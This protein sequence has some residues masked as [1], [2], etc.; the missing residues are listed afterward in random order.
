MKHNV[1]LSGMYVVYQKIIDSI[2]Q[3]VPDIEFSFNYAHVMGM[4]KLREISRLIIISD[5]FNF[6]SPT[7]SYNATRGQEA[8]EYLHRVDPFLPILIWS[9]RRYYG[10]DEDFPPLWTVEG[11][12]WPLKFD[13][14][15][16][17]EVMDYDLDKIGRISGEFIKGTLQAKQLNHECLD[18]S[19]NYF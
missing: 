16:Y 8:A 10:D 18:M 3:Q 12:P 15:L 6:S 9:G 4:V 19:R 13:S 7:A 11:E 2:K 14:E 17:L 1:L 5:V